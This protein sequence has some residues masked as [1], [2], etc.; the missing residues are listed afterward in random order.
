MSSEN[1]SNFRN[2]TAFFKKH[3]DVT[4]SEVFTFFRFHAMLIFVRSAANK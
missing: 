1:A 4:R 3:P 2:R